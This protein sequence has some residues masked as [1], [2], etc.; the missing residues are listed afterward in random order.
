MTSKVVLRDGT[1]EAAAA[2]AAGARVVARSWRAGLNV[3]GGEPPVWGRARAAVA[4]VA[5]LRELTPDD[6]DAILRLDQDTATDY[7]GDV[8]TTHRP[9]TADAATP[10][11]YRRAFGAVVGAD[12]VAMTVVDVDGDRAETD[13][14]VVSRSWRGRGLA[15]AVKA[16]S[17][18]TLAAAG[19]R[20]FRTGG[21]S[22]NRAIIAVNEA[23]GYVRDEEWLTLVLDAEQT[24]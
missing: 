19:V 3:D 9:L 16:L 11:P 10:T 6:R 8:A 13:F 17:L 7:P 2:L 15:A 1:P 4:D 20:R 23:L 14:T 21:S 22:E 12:L 18:G 24:G 5:V